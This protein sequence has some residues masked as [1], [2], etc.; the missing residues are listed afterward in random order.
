MYIFSYCGAITGNLT[1][2][3]SVRSPLL[4]LQVMVGCGV[5]VT[6]QRMVAVVPW[7]MVSFWSGASMTAVGLTAV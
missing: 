5:P 6:S 2:C 1:L 4:L 3:L 7:S